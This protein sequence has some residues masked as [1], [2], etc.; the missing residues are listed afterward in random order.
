MLDQMV[1]KTEAFRCRRKFALA[2]TIESTDMQK[3]AQKR[4]RIMYPRS[5]IPN[6]EKSYKNLFGVTGY[7]NVYVEI[8]SLIRLITLIFSL[9]IV[10][11]C[12]QLQCNCRLK[13]KQ[14]TCNVNLFQQ[15]IVLSGDTGLSD[16]LLISVPV[17]LSL[18]TLSLLRFSMIKIC[19]VYS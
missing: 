12:P 4:E 5:N 1:F 9:I 19:F 2:L 15:A 14:C 7:E 11:F 16:Y 8:Q 13:C 10:A 17:L 6:L 3:G 18:D